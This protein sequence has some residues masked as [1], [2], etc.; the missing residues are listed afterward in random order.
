MS[1]NV[2][3]RPEV[4]QEGYSGWPWSEVAGEYGA[5]VRLGIRLEMSNQGLTFTALAK[6]IGMAPIM[7]IGVLT[8]RRSL[9]NSVVDA[10]AKV[11]GVSVEKLAQQGR[12]LVDEKSLVFADAGFT[13]S[14]NVR[15]EMAR[16]QITNKALAELLGCTPTTVQNKLTG[17]L[18][19]TAK[20]IT[21]IAELLDVPTTKLIGNLPA[22]R[23]LEWS[24]R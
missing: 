23:A 5:A 2:L 14:D 24:R 10:V 18:R 12:M 16:R 7:L 17:G 20:E 8:D 13:V 4:F 3:V 22:E 9:T 15:A 11:L 19:F 6:L 21:R 1:M